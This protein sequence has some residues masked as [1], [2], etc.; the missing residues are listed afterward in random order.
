MKDFKKDFLLYWRLMSF[1]R[2]YWRAM[3]AAVI[4][5][6]VAAAMEPLMPALM[7]PLVDESLIAKD[8]TSLWLV[9]LGLVLVVLLRGL[10][11]YAA[12]YS[13]AYLS[14]RTIE[15]LRGV[16]FKKELELS[17]TD[18][19]SDSPGRMLTRI[20]YDTEMVADAVSSVWMVVIRDTFVIVGL[21]AFLFYTAWHLAL[22]VFLTLPVLMLAIRWIGQRLRVSSSRL[23]IHHGRIASFVQEALL[24]LREIKLFKAYRQQSFDFGKI[25]YQLRR[26]FLKSSRISAL[27]GPIVAT[28][29]AVTVALVIYFASFVTI[30]GGLTPGE[31]VA[32]ITALAMVFGPIRRLSAVHVTLQRGLASAEAIFALIDRPSEA[33]EQKSK[34][35][36]GCSVRGLIEFQ[37]VCFSYPHQESFALRSANFRVE[38][39]EAIALIGPSGAGKSTVLNLIAGFYKPTGGDIFLD[40]RSYNDWSVDTIRSQISLVG[41]N[42]V[43]FDGTIFENIQMGSLK[44]PQERVAWAA[45]QAR[46][47]EFIEQLPDGINTPLGSMGGRLS[48]GQ[49]QR[50]AIA[51][52]FLKNAPILL[53]DE[54][55]SALDR[56]NEV[57]VIDAI[58]TLMRGRTVLWV[59]HSPERLVGIDRTISIGA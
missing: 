27:A 25:S 16:V 46:A 22:F 33:V 36:D 28:L 18:H 47:M 31:F 24:G 30:S 44:A 48:G 7:K 41:Q 54:P 50:I 42:V 12:T 59:S 40:G 34:S 4:S 15:D 2:P 9:P 35:S 37:N 53:L 10:A 52:A 8:S 17:L 19:A 23:Q 45:R 43:L 51:R 56:E 26:E 39:G 57:A 1:A 49:R 21:V 11:D 29:T 32:F 3:V 6:L 55:T 58:K 13:S 5:V 14:G 20:T 38:A